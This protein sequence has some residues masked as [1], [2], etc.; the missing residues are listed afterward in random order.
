M[1]QVLTLVERDGRVFW[2]RRIEADRGAIRRRMVGK[3]HVG[4]SLIVDQALAVE[5][6]F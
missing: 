1:R 2:V 4:R 3:S 5:N 6:I